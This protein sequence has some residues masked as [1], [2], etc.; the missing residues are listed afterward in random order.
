MILLLY[1]NGSQLSKPDQMPPP[2]THAHTHHPPEWCPLIEQVCRFSDLLQ[3]AI[4]WTNKFYLSN[5]CATMLVVCALLLLL[6]GYSATT[7]PRV[8][9][10][11]DSSDVREYSHSPPTDPDCP[12]FGDEDFGLEDSPVS[13][14]R[15]RELRGNFQSSNPQVIII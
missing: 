6:P 13:R 10:S 4:N 5:S 11:S 7:L 15:E 3:L 14:R 9:D 1:Q 2:F 12:S 8:G